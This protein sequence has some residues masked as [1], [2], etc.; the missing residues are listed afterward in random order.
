MFGFVVLEALPVLFLNLL[1]VKV[2]YSMSRCTM[3]L[4]SWMTKYRFGCILLK[5]QK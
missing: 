4:R 5:P 3:V 1:D 2:I